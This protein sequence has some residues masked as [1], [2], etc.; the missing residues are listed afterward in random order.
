MWR[1][2]SPGAYSLCSANSIDVPACGLWW[3]PANAPSTITRART[4][5]DDRRAKSRGSSTR[6]VLRPGAEMS[7]SGGGAGES[8][9][10]VRAS[11][12]AASGLLHAVDELA[13]QRA[14]GQAVGLGVEVGQNPVHQHRHCERA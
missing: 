2:S 11:G 7:V 12:L 5:S 4:A 9:N 13:H 6:G 8:A 1:T 3:V 14:R 10:V